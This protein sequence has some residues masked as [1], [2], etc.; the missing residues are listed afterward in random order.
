MGLFDTIMGG[1]E[2]S[3]AQHAAL[4]A[5]VAKLVD[6]SGGVAGLTQKFEQQ[7]LGTLVAGWIGTGANPPISNDQVAQVVSPE[8]IQDI[9]AKTGLPADQVTAAIT[10]ILPLVVDHLTPDGAIPEHNS[11][12]MNAALGELKSKLFG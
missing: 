9:A 8:K 2:A 10:K 3:D 7:G 11:A 12:L 4:Y 6:E 5:E 1:I